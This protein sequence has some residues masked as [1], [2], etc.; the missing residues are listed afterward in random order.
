MKSKISRGFR[1]NQF[2]K[3][4]HNTQNWYVRI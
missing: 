1:G 4:Y 2:W 3:L